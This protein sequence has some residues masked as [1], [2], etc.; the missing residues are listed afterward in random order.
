MER[1]SILTSFFNKI[2]TWYPILSLRVRENLLSNTGDLPRISSERCLYLILMAIGSLAQY[3]SLSAALRE[4]P[5]APLMEEVLLLL[6]TVLLEN[7]L[8]ALQC[9]IFVSTYYLCLVKP[10][11]AH[12]YILI[13]SIRARNLLK[14]ASLD[15]E[16]QELIR[17]ALWAALLIESELVTQLDLTTRSVWT[18]DNEIPLPSWSQP[19]DEALLSPFSAPADSPGGSFSSPQSSNQLLSYFLAETIMRR[20]LQRCTT[21]TQILPNG[22]QMFAPVISTELELQ[23]EQWHTHLPEFLRFD[24]YSM[25]EFSINPQLLFLRTQY[26]AYR[27]SILWPAVHQVVVEGEQYDKSLLS[28]CLEF[29]QDYNRFVSS[30]VACIPHCLPNTWTLYARYGDSLLQPFLKR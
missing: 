10:C 18:L 24:R 9:L 6:P 8:T 20:M 29:Y 3:E 30:A 27:A 16:N 13:A 5:D 17:R 7:S 22:K 2:H 1:G 15:P 28:F 4:R 25:S 21:S 23:L 11:Q 19:V 12:D 26:Y 14:S